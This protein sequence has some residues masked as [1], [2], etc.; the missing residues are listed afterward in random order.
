MPATHLRSCSSDI[1]PQA[2]LSIAVSASLFEL[3]LEEPKG[4]YTAFAPDSDN[5]EVYK[6]LLKFVTCYGARA[7]NTLRASYKDANSVVT[8]IYT[9]LG[10]IQVSFIRASSIAPD[11]K[12]SSWKADSLPMQWQ[13]LFTNI[14]N[15]L[16]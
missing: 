12:S 5:P 14:Y 8:L 13:K 11:T 15:A 1:Y 10:V 9:S 7:R 16:T 6:L 4:T 2:K 3:E